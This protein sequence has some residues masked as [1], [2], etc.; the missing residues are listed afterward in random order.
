MGG[1]LPVSWRNSQR[2]CLAEPRDWRLQEEAVALDQISDAARPGAE[3]VLHFRLDFGE[4][5]PFGVSSR[6]LVKYASVAVLDR[7]SRSLFLIAIPWR[8]RRCAVVGVRDRRERSTHRVRAVGLGDLAMASG[9]GCVT[10]V[11][12]PRLRI[13]VRRSAV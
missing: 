11:A 3:S 13:C 12:D 9:A 8:R 10:D 7:V 1:E 2:A 6:R 4:E 5:S